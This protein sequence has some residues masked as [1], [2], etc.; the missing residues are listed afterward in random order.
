M[1]MITKDGGGVPPPEL[2]GPGSTLSMNVNPDNVIRYAVVFQGEADRFA[3]LLRGIVDDLTVV[4]WLGDPVSI[5]V[6]DSFNEHHGR[7][8]AE[9]TKLGEQ[10]RLGAEALRASADR[11]G[12]TEELNQAMLA[13]GRV[14]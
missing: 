2:P 9:L 4:P 3:T 10:Y 6:A 8:I 1:A 13:A 11:Y 5:W 12:L 14:A 7:L